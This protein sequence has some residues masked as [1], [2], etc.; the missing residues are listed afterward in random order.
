MVLDL[1]C[2]AVDLLSPVLDVLIRLATDVLNVANAFC[3]SSILI[4]LF[5]YL[6]YKHDQGTHFKVSYLCHH[7]IN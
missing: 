2:R 6:R 1:C 3:S 5:D 7:F 4:R